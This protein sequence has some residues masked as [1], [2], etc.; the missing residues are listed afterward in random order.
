MTAKIT[1]INPDRLH[2]PP[3]YHHVTVVEAGRTAFLAGQS[4]IALSGALVGEG[5]INAQLDQVAENALIALAAVG[6]R[7]SDV[8]RTVVYVV[9]DDRSVLAAAWDRLIQSAIG[10]AFTTASTL[11]GVAQLGYAGQLVEVDLTAALPA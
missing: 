8:V 3:T 1:R 6:A 9:S 5:D 4:P 7:P 11:L 10:A 2:A